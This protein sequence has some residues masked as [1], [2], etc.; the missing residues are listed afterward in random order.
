VQIFVS[1]AREDLIT[2][3]K[4]SASL[5]QYKLEP[6]L[7]V[8]RLQPGQNWR[9]TIE[10]AI[11]ASAFFVALLSSNSVNKRGYVQKELRTALD[12]LQEMPPSRP[13]R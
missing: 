3:R 4:I 13:H 9:Q 6:W 11:K 2:A 5:Q 10:S 1:Y 8:E 7:D 12:V